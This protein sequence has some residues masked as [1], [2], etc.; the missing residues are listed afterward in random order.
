M[1]GTSTATTAAR[2]SLR[3]PE[4]RALADSRASLRRQPRVLSAN[5]RRRPNRVVVG[6]REKN[7]LAA[8]RVVALADEHDH[9]VRLRAERVPAQIVGLLAVDQAA[10]WRRV[11]KIGEAASRASGA[12]SPLLALR[13]ANGQRRETVLRWLR[14]LRERRAR[15]H[16][17]SDCPHV[18]AAETR[19]PVQADP[20][21]GSMTR[22]PK[23]PRVRLSRSSRPWGRGP[24]RSRPAAARLCKAATSHAPTED[25]A[26]PQL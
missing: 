18:G 22:R 21:H 20:A 5:D 25:P 8:A 24:P 2:S 11:V 12:A 4:R 17:R 26:T 9:P 23:A 10:V 13:P 1:S 14:T 15:S 3:P 6:G 19:I 16:H 7:S